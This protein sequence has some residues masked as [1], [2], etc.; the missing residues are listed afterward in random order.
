MALRRAERDA[1]RGDRAGFGAAHRAAAGV[2]LQ[3]RAVADRLG[4][5]VYSTI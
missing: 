1:R 4:L 2:S 3:A 5:E